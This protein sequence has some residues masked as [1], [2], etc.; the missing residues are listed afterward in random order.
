MFKSV[1]LIFEKVSIDMKSGG[2]EQR[3]RH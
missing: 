3:N 2:R 1:Y